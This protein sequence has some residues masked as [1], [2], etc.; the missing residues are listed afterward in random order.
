MYLAT[1]LHKNGHNTTC[2]QYFFMKFAPLDSA[3]IARATKKYIF[4]K[5]PKCSGPFSH[6]RSHMR[7]T[8][9]DRCSDVGV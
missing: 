9:L 3:H 4:M 7:K 8:V 2:D 1:R 6:S 5:Y